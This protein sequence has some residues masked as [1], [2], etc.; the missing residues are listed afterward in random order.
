MF[1]TIGNP[2]Y[3][4]LC[5]NTRY[6]SSSRTPPGGCYEEIEENKLS[7]IDPKTIALIALVLAVAG[8]GYSFITSGP[9]G[10]TG[11]QGP[12]GVQGIQGIEGSQG[13]AQRTE[14]V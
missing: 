3:V 7:E 1:R 14:P 12:Q 2:R 10:P 5:K 13:T 4:V 11:L 9:E 8:I 6:P